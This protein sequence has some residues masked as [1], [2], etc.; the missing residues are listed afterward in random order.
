MF[1][2]LKTIIAKADSSAALYGFQFAMVMA[3]SVVNED[4]SLGRMYETEGV[5]EVRYFSDWIV[6]LVGITLM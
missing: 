6:S 1:T 5:K 4:A 3:G 2:D